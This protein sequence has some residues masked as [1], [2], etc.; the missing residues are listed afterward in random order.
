MICTTSESM[1]WCPKVSSCLH[2]QYLSKPLI[3]HIHISANILTWRTYAT[4]KWFEEVFIMKPA[5]HYYS[6]EKCAIYNCVEPSTNCTYLFVG[7]NNAFCS[8][9]IVSII[10]SL[11]GIEPST[12]PY[13]MLPYSPLSYTDC[14]N[15]LL[16]WQQL[17]I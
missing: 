15:Q 4:N 16:M 6:C 2:H 10:V 14:S 12:S 17:K 1:R 5:C 7:K 9:W 11:S 13:T 3:G 8:L